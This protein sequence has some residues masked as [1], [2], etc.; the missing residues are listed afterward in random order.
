MSILQKYS[1]DSSGVIQPGNRT[2]AYII[3]IGALI[4]IRFVAAAFLPLYFGDEP[5]YWLWSQNLSWGYFDHPPAIAFLIR[6]GT[7]LFGDTEFGVRFFG[8]LLSIP[9]TMCVW[10]TGT[11]LLGGTEHGAR[12]AL[13][14]NL[15]LMVHA[16]TFMVTPDAPVLV[17]CA[18]LLW[19]VAEAETSKN[20]RWWLMA[21]LFAGLGLLSKYTI[22]FVGAGVFLWLL[23]TVSGRNWLTTCWPWIGGTIAL[24]VFSPNLIWN[25]NQDFGALGFQF[26]RLLFSGR[27][28]WYYLPQLIGEQ[29][30]LAS[31]FILALAL[32]GLWHITVSKDQRRLLIAMQIWPFIIFALTYVFVD[33]IHRNWSDV[34]YPALALAAADAFRNRLG[35]SLVRKIAAP[36][37]LSILVI[38]Y[39][40][41]LFHVVSLAPHDPLDHHLA[42]TTRQR[43][44]PI[45]KAIADA[46]A[47]GV[48]TTDFPVTSWL[49]FYLRPQPPIIMVADDFRFPSAPRAT[50]EHLDGTL[51]YV[52]IKDDMLY[53]LRKGF[54][55]IE[56]VTDLP[57]TPFLI[58][59][60][61]GF[62]GLP[63]GRL[64]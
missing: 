52:A 23:L 2:T 36:T 54:S 62:K 11:L 59:R 32:M 8:L 60:V 63:Y 48:L 47:R 1:I 27:G 3:A 26:S 50:A 57:P 40:Q 18:A 19:A 20:G 16:V 42:S 21:G 53:V 12:A 6:S 29:F 35:P 28:R 55:K 22:L 24:I 15:T 7:I 58:Y 49:R 30:L 46:N 64:P 61:S 37:A 13:I 31:P 34:V 14:F 5:Y 9:A 39:V 51:I 45:Q 38:V 10:R 44:L 41:M 33:R 43:T 4:G 25:L 17:C 56:R